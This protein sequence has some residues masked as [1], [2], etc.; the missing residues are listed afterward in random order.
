MRKSYCKKKL[1]SSESSRK[2]SPNLIQSSVYTICHLKLL[3]I[4]I[5]LKIGVIGFGINKTYYT[6]TRARLHDV[7]F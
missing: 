7:T 5:K 4:K 2:S 6:Y 3:F 1:L